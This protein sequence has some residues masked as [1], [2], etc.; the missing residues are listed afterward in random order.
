[1]RINTAIALFIAVLTVSSCVA[2][3]SAEGKAAMILLYYEGT[4]R[5]HIPAVAW[6]AGKVIPRFVAGAEHD[7]FW[8]QRFDAAPKFDL[9]AETFNQRQSLL[10]GSSETQSA[11]V[12]EFLYES[13]RPEIRYLDQRNFE[14]VRM[15]FR[16]AQIKGHEIL[17]D[18]PTGEK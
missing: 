1:M 18:W 12:V 2:Q 4:P 6:Y 15:A 5:A 7:A 10:R 9:T 16:E 3:P 13:E 11:Y 14:R 8:K 17:A